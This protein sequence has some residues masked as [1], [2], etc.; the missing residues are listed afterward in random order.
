MPRKKQIQIGVENGIM[1]A[2][3]YLVLAHGQNSLAEYMLRESGID[4][5][6]CGDDYDRRALAAVISELKRKK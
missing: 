4:P 3:A 2:A 1:W 5:N 6:T